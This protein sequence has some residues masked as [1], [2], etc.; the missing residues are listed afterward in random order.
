[1]YI[2]VF[3]EGVLAPSEGSHYCGIFQPTGIHMK[4]VCKCKTYIHIYV[5]IYVYI[6]IFV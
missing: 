5:Y 4:F 1:M 3:G 6:F 2:F